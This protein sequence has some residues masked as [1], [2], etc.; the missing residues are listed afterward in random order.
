MDDENYIIIGL[1]I[2]ALICIFCGYITL[3][4]V[5]QGVG[6]IG[7]GGILVILARII[8]ARKYQRES[9]RRAEWLTKQVAEN[10]KKS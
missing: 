7:I 5:T 8:Q 10:E 6:I 9:K 3:S 1:V 2:G 4:D